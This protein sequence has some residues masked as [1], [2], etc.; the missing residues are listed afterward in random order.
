MESRINIHN[1]KVAK[2]K[3]SAQTRTCNCI[4]KL[5][6]PLNNKCLSNNVLYKANITSSQ[7]ITEIKFTT[8]SVR[9]SSSHDTQTIENLLKTENTKQTLNF[10]MK[11]GSYRN[12]TK[13]LIYR[14]KF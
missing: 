5:K 4:N 12:K 6:C 1:K 9:P 13:M 3:P 8:A 10:P 11:S 14:G 7:R 2:A